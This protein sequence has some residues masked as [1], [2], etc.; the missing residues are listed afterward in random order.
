M[1]ILVT[2]FS[3]SHGCSRLGTARAEGT[4]EYTTCD[5]LLNTSG[6]DWPQSSL[7][8]I[9]A[10]G[11]ALD[12]LVIGKPALSSGDA[13]SGYIAPATLADCLEQAKSQGWGAS[14]CPLCGLCRTLS[15]HL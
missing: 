13:S 14:P 10:S 7:F 4:T 2:R 11:V 1:P 8:E 15:E 12:K 9:A 5:G 3:H 6:G